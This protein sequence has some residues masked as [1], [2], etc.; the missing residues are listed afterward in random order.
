[1]ININSDQGRIGKL[2]WINSDPQPIE[3]FI[4]AVVGILDLGMLVKARLIRWGT[5]GIGRNIRVALEPIDD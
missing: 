3:E 1:M 2:W 5:C 4:P